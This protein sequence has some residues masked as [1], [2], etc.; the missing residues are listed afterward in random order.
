MLTAAI[1]ILLDGPIK[2]INYNLEEIVY[3]LSCMYNEM[4]QLACHYDVQFTSILREIEGI[5]NSK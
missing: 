3:S 5:V 4:S 1:G 2:S